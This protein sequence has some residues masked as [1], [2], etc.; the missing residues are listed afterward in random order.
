MILPTR[1]CRALSFVLAFGPDADRLRPGAAVAP[2]DLSAELARQ[3][4]LTAELEVLRAHVNEG[5]APLAIAAPIDGHA[6]ESP[7]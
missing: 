5:D 7:E 2:A 3:R 1:Q 6:V 4:A